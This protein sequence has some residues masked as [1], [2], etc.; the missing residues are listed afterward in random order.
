M[1]NVLFGYHTFTLQPKK[2]STSL[3][4]SSAF[5]SGL[6]QLDLLLFLP[7]VAHILIRPIGIAALNLII[8]RPTFVQ[9]Q[10]LKC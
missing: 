7:N 10:P 1:E 2:Y 3:S 8:C 5:S 6:L 9:I 4:Q